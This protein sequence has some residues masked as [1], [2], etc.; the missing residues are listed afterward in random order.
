MPVAPWSYGGSEDAVATEWAD[1]SNPE[2]VKRLVARALALFPQVHILVNNAGVYGPMGADRD[3]STGTTWVRAMEINSTAR[4][5]RAARCC[6]TSKRSATARSSSSPAAARPIRCRG[7]APMRRRRRRSCGSPNRWRSRC[8][9]FDIDVN[10]IAP[11]ALNTRM[12]DEVLAAGPD[13]VGQASTS[14]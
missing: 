9:A 4:C 12:M 7:S 3:R 8:K 5:C 11:G 2:D 10:A 13:T 14:A 6:R 1:V